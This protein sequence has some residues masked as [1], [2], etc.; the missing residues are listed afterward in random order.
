V[1]GALGNYLWL[2]TRAVESSGEFERHRRSAHPL[3]EAPKVPGVFGETGESV[4]LGFVGMLD[5]ARDEDTLPPGEL[6][7]PTENT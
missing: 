2:T 6:A 1:C 4:L 7:A 5:V 3:L